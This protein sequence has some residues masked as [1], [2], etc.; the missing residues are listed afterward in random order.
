MALGARV[1]ETPRREE[2]GQA[3]FLGR[4]REY[5]LRF[6]QFLHEVRVEMRNV[7]WPTMETVRSTTAVVII[8]V[9]VFGLFL[10]VVD[11][12]VSQVVQEILTRFR[13]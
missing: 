11:W 3:G 12:G 6:R 10:F 4:V 7:N 9:F 8:T 1:A 2:E 5:P 13:R